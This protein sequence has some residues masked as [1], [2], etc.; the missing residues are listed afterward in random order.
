MALAIIGFSLYIYKYANVI[1]NNMKRKY[2]YFTSS[3]SPFD[4]ESLEVSFIL[5]NFYERLNK[6]YSE[7]L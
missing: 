4:L 2:V 7:Y 1:N 6:S 5:N 3:P